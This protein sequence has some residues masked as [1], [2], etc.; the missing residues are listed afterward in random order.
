MP[1]LV[2]AR[3]NHDL[4][5]KSLLNTT[6]N[7][8]C[9]AQTPGIRSGLAEKSAIKLLFGPLRQQLLDLLPAAF[10]PPGAEHHVQKYT[11]VI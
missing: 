1:A 10:R 6:D 3:F 8:S 2:A 4:K 9:G 11:K 7:L 5:G